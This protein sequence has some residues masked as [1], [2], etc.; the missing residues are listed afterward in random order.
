[1]I[2]DCAENAFKTA[3]ASHPVTVLLF[4]EYS[5]NRRAAK[6]ESEAEELSHEERNK[7]EN[8]R[9][10]WKDDEF[11]LPQPGLRIHRTKDWDA[12]VEWIRQAKAEGHWEQTR[13][14]ET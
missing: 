6:F 2:D 3:A 8:W 12:V 9:E 7:V 11:E 5:W 10:W 13:H 14:T 4:G 1:M